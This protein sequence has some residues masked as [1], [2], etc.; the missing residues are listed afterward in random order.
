[1]ARTKRT[2]EVVGTPATNEFEFVVGQDTK[3]VVVRRTT[4]EGKTFVYEIG[5]YMNLN[6]GDTI[7]LKVE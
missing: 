5:K 2:K 6:P 7:T 4:T 3:N 1:M